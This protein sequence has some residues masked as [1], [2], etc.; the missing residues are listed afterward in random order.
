M[1]VTARVTSHP[2]DDSNQLSDL[3]AGQALHLSQASTGIVGSTTCTA[4]ESKVNSSYGTPTT[5]V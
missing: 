4:L 5:Y 2:N 3:E 1:A